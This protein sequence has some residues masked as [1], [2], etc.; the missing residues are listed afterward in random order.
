MAAGLRL[1][2]RRPRSSPRARP[3]LHPRM[4]N[5]SPTML[6]TLDIAFGMIDMP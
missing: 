4:P 6:N 3:F 1:A 5:I 2:T